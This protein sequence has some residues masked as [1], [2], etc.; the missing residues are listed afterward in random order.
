[1]DCFQVKKIKEFMAALLMREEFDRYFVQEVEIVTYNTFRIDGHIQKSFYSKEEYEEL[2]EPRLTRWKKLRPLCFEMIKGSK[3]PVRFKIIL[4][5]AN[6]ETEELF[7]QSQVSISKEQLDG[8]YLN[9]MYENDV[10]QGIS[11]TSLNIFT[12]DKTLEKAWDKRI[13]GLLEQYM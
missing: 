12:M 2:E 6:E 13:N 3:T 5:A 4:R 1:M 8:L 10:L 7:Q 9:L 11:A